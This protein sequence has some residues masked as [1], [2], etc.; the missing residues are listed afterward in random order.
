[1]LNSYIQKRY[2]EP[3]QTEGRCPTALTDCEMKGKRVAGARPGRGSTARLV[4][5]SVPGC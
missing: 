4:L 1:M 3:G 5:Q 2:A